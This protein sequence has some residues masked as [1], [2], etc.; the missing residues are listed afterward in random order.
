MT[1]KP[2]FRL[3][4]LG[5]IFLFIHGCSTLAVQQQTTADPTHQYF[6]EIAFGSEFGSKQTRIKKWR[7]NIHL[8]VKGQPTETDLQTLK[9]VITELNGLVTPDI[10]IT[11]NDANMEM[12]FIPER[13][14]SE[15]DKDYQPRNLGYFW[16][17]WNPATYEIYRARILIS[18]TGITQQE[19]NHLI[20]EELTQSLG[21]MNDSQHYPDSI[22]YQPWS[23]VTD[24]SKIDKD[25][26]KLLYQSDIR[27][28]MSKS[29]TIN[30]LT[31][32][33]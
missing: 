23:R 21:L 13:R 15:I 22:F 2:T 29:Q 27:P 18:S 10:T 32:I 4:L 7:K 28:G 25:I 31:A 33:Q 26:I 20:R 19:R 6:M 30:R 8:Q 11:H 12:H 9:Q 16:T 24:Y 17:W 1:L 3:F 5:L 14:F